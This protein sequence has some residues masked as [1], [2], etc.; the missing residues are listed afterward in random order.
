MAAG[1]VAGRKPV[2]PALVAGP[3]ACPLLPQRATE[4]R[5]RRVARRVSGGTLP[6]SRAHAQGHDRM[7]GLAANFTESLA[8]PKVGIAFLPRA[9]T[10]V[11]RPDKPSL[12]AP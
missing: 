8:S 9:A 2:G 5:N 7:P 6:A 1:C 3:K 12:P 10:L 11:V 4:P